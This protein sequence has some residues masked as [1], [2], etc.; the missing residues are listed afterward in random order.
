MWI[1]TCLFADQLDEVADAMD[2]ARAV[3]D[4]VR[5]DAVIVDSLARKHS[6]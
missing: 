1:I 4:S 5:T 3:A 2:L 6:T